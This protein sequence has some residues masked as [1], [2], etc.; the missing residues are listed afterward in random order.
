M[1]SAKAET[2]H[3]V[4]REL[5][6]RLDYRY[7][8]IVQESGIDPLVA[9]ERDYYLEKTKKGLERLVHDQ[10]TSWEMERCS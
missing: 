8:E 1:S 10:A 2:R 4:D 5:R 6:R 7:R 9:A 3:D